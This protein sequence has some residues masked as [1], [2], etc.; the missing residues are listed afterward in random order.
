[1]ASIWTCN[2]LFETIFTE[3]NMTI[4]NYVKRVDRAK[5][6]NAKDQ[7]NNLGVLCVLSEAGVRQNF[8]RWLRSIGLMIS[9]NPSDAKSLTLRV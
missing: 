3:V 1:M 4:V 9:L 5:Q 2:L 6:S 7:K 8:Y